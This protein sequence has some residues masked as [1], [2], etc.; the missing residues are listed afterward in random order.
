MLRLLRRR[1]GLLALVLVA[2]SA[3]AAPRTEPPPRNLHEAIRRGFYSTDSKPLPGGPERVREFVERGADLE[4]R[5]ADGRTPYLLAASLGDAATMRLLAGRGARRDVTDTNGDTAFDLALAGRRGY[6]LR[7]LIDEGWPLTS[8]HRFQFACYKIA[9]A[10][11]WLLPFLIGASF[12]AGR[13]L[14]RFYAHP[15]AIGR[16]PSGA[17]QLPTL[18]PIKCGP[19]G[20][21]VPLRLH[22]MRCPSCGT[23]ATAPAEWKKTITLREKTAELLARAERLWERARLVSAAPVR[24]SLTLLALVLLV[25]VG[26][27]LFSR[28]GDSLFAVRLSTAFVGASAFLGGLSLVAALLGYAFYLGEVQSILPVPVAAPA[29]TTTTAQCTTCA[30]GIEH[31]GR[32]LSTLCGYCGT[33]NYRAALTGR[34]LGVAHTEK[35]AAKVSLYEAMRQIVALRDK[36]CTGLATAALVV[37]GLAVGALL[38]L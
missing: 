22:G 1:F 10:A 6:A 38:V 36:A 9:R 18:E 16:Q 17:D 28:L 24:L 12:L 23:P 35:G 13:F 21:S 11:G 19:C 20:G 29:E 3:P 5:D 26:I 31:R 30:G 32:A 37:G 25:L 34:E 7:L 33:E 4:A 14:P 2:A 8:K 15:P 27:G